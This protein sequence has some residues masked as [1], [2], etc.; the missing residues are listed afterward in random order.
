[1]LFGG[2]HM[3]RIFSKRFWRG[4]TL[5]ELL[6]VIAIIA[7]L[8]GL[9]L[10]AVQK[11]RE[12]A[13]KTS[14]GDNLH[15][16]CIAAVNC[17]DQHD[18][19]LPP[20]LGLY[21]YR[22]G[23]TNNGEGGVLFHLL[24]YVEQDP[25]YKRSLGT[26]DRN[27]NLPTY[28]QWN[29]QQVKVKIYLCPADPTTEGPWNWAQSKTSY[30]ANGQVFTIAYQWGWGQGYSK[31]PASFNP[32]GTSNTVLFADKQSEAYYQDSFGNGGWSPDSGYNYWPDWG[33][34][35]ASSE[36]GQPVGIA[37]MFQTGPYI[38][39]DGTRAPDCANGNLY[40]SPHNNGI[41]VGMGDGSVR[42][43]AN[44]VS[45]STWWAALTPAAGDLLGADW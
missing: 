5:I 3:P 40:N 45:P 31:F 27:S 37:A 35:V 13:Q 9:L 36:G 1:F 22:E 23:R 17:A 41:M 42:F 18:S 33:P 38:C 44:T 16:L 4:F 26:D 10:P 7:I 32:D 11:V 20:G 8:I 25:P 14:C 43:V 30:G 12:A 39:R 28:S 15:N 24:P 2:R 29:A 6:V 34:V 21:P 19:R